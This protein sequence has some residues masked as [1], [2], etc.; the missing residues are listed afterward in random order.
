[1]QPGAPATPGSGQSPGPEATGQW[2]FN[3]DDDTAGP[4]PAGAAAAGQETTWT[5]SEYIAHQKSAGWY[6]AL[7]LGAVGLALLVWF[8]TD[9]VTSGVVIM[10]VA[11][12]FGAMAARSPRVLNYHLD[13]GGL[14]IGEKFYPYADFKSFSVLE[15]GPIDSILL[16][17]MKRFMPGLTVYYPPEQEDA[18]FA[19]LGNYLPHEVREP[20]ALD[21]LMRKVRF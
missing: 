20:D 14:H 15:E 3:P 7:G 19:V 16:L 21:R 18:I 17:P 1:M 13:H 9:D 2:Q 11:I 5:A 12:I 6:M 4:A 10:I 8:I